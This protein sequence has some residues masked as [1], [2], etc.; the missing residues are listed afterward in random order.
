MK[1]KQINNL[2]QL[3]AEIENGYIHRI[4]TDNY[5]KSIIML[6]NDTIDM[7][8]E[9]SEIPKYTRQEYVEKVRELIKERYAI[10]D[11][12]ALYRQ[13]DV[14][15]KE[16]EE[17]NQYCEDCKVKAKELLNNIFNITYQ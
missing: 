14:K 9:V 12:I 15:A 6:P 3:S 8:E 11:E 7:F 5:Y 10:E 1:T 17:Y 16:F 2:V 4:G 13:K